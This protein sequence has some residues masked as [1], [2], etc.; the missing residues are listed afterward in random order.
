MAHT[1]TGKLNKAA[2]QFQAGEST[3]FG[4]RIGEKH[5]NRESG[6]S[7]WTNYK[8][9]VFAKNPNQIAFYQSALIEGAIVSVSGES[10]KIDR[11]QGQNGEVLTLELNGARVEFVE[12][13]QTQQKPQAPQGYAQ[14]QPPQHPQQPPMQQRPAPP[15][16]YQPA[17]PGNVAQ[18]P[19]N[20]FNDFD[21]D[22]AF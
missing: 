4:I 6:Q 14:P 17:R 11:Y 7:E 8:A 3:G 15:P 22:I 20:Q 18:Q 19:Q 5:Y 16:G 21:D 9:A 2:T 13:P 10:I 12:S 1:V